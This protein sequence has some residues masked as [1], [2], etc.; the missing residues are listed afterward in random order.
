MT[1]EEEEKAES[2]KDERAERWEH[3]QE[4][5]KKQNPVKYAAKK[6][7]GKFARIP[8]SFK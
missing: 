6:A 3:L 4:V 8:D 1:K 7:A 5:Y 2:K